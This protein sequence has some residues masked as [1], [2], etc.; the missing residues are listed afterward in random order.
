MGHPGYFALTSLFLHYNP[1]T[2]LKNASNNAII[3]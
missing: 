2:A 3:V 1:L